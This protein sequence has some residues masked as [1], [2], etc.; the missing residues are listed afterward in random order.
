MLTKTLTDGLARYQMSDVL[1]VDGTL[2]QVP[3]L[4]FLGR[5]DGVDLVGEK[6]SATMAQAVQD[7]LSLQ[8][9][10]PVTLL[11]FLV[12]IGL[13]VAVHEY[14]H[15]RV[16]RALGFRVLTFSVGFGR[17]LWQ[18]SGRDG[19]EYRIGLL[20][21]GGYVR[22]AGESPRAAAA[23][24]VVA[25]ALLRSTLSASLLALA[26]LIYANFFSN[27][28]GHDYRWWIFGVALVLR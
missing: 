9:A 1:R 15:F 21:L 8:G 26:A 2:G 19:V 3:C 6:T 18:R 22:M 14:G 23:G 16:A 20:P 25:A 17:P 27:Y 11:A 28:W 10:L 13:L 24:C 12:A 7:G 5:N 4:T